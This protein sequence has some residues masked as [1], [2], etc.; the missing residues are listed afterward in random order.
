[1][2]ITDIKIY[3][4]DKADTVLN[5]PLPSCISVFDPYIKW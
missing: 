4:G 3:I 5:N 2:E 1:M